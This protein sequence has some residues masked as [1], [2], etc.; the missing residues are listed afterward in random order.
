MVRIRFPPA[1]SRVRTRLTSHSPRPS[2][3][4]WMLWLLPEV[5]IQAG[6]SPAV[7]L[8]YSAQPPGVTRFCPGTPQPPHPRTGENSQPWEQKPAVDGGPTLKLAALLVREGGLPS[9]AC[10]EVPHDATLVSSPPDYNMA[11]GRMVNQPN[12]TAV[13]RSMLLPQGRAP[14]KG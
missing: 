4:P 6:G 9:R 2:G 14:R 11:I 12:Y 1:E 13:A 10:F 8:D 7:A 3:H 5:V